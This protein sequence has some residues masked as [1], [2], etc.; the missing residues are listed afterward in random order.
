MII[1]IL[2]SA[3]ARLWLRQFFYICQLNK[4]LFWCRNNS[5]RHCRHH[6]HRFINVKKVIIRMIL[7]VDHRPVD[8]G[9]CFIIPVYKFYIN[10]QIWNNARISSTSVSQIGIVL[11]FSQCNRFF[12]TRIRKS[13]DLEKLMM[14]VCRYRCSLINSPTVS[15]RKR[16]PPSRWGKPRTQSPWKAPVGFRVGANLPFTACVCVCVLPVLLMSCV[17]QL[18]STRAL[19]PSNCFRND[20]WFEKT[21]RVSGRKKY[22][23]KHVKYPL[24]VSTVSYFWLRSNFGE[25]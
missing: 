2:S 24:R 7:K 20:G 21:A 9:H 5:L 22:K 10:V 14:N 13:N 23:Q 1:I 15:I 3:N 4:S 25:K 11:T 12:D 6:R 18:A 17:A 19:S 8:R 16:C